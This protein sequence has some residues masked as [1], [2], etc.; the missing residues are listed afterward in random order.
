MTH[1]CTYRYTSEVV[2]SRVKVFDIL[3]DKLPF[4]FLPYVTFGWYVGHLFAQ[5]Y[6][7]LREPTVWG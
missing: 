6:L 7:P 2:Y 5:F 1:T 4:K 3:D